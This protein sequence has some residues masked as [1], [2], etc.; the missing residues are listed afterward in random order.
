MRRYGAP[1][2][3]IVSSL[4]CHAGL[5]HASED[6]VSGAR[7]Q[8]YS[9]VMRRGCDEAMLSHPR[10][11]AFPP[12]CKAVLNHVLARDRRD[13]QKPRDIALLQRWHMRVIRALAGEDIHG[14]G[15]AE[16]VERGQHHRDLGQVGA[17]VFTVTKLEQAILS[18]LPVAAGSSAIHPYGVYR[19]VLVH[20][21]S[22]PDSA[23][24]V[25]I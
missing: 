9:V 17:M 12:H 4:N 13:R 18:N 1:H 23:N 6:K 5:K 15:H 25:Q 11:I 21:T 22:L 8:L 20:T 16:R 2:R 19:G 3:V 24:P 7:F 10:L 14:H